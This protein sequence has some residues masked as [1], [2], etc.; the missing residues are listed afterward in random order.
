[1]SQFWSEGMRDEAKEAEG[2]SESKM[3]KGSVGKER[4]GVTA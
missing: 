2:G 1:M 3:G 4:E